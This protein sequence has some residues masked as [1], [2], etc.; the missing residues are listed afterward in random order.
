VFGAAAL[1]VA[2]LLVVAVGS[3]FVVSQQVQ[4]DNVQQALTTASNENTNLQLE[5]AQLASPT[6]ILQVAQARLGMVTPASVT[7]LVPVKLGPTVGSTKHSLG[8]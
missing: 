6:K 5:R 7:Y 1:V 3:A 8:S 2:A 4:L